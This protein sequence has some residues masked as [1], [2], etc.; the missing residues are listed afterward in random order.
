MKRNIQRTGLW[1]SFLCFITYTTTL[2]QEL[3]PAKEHRHISPGHTTYYIDPS[4]GK[5]ENAGTS[6]RKAWRTFTPVNQLQLT[7]GDKLEILPGAFQRSLVLMAQGDSAVHVTIHFAPGRYDFYPD[8]PY[9]QLLHISNTND[10]PDLPKAMAIYLD[11]SGYVDIQASGAIIVLRGKMIETCINQSHDVHIEG[12]SYDYFRPTVSEFT[13]TRVGDGFADL[14]IH[15]DSWY[16][17]QAGVLTWEGEGWRY[18]S[19]WYWQ[20]YDPE[21]DKVTRCD[22]GFQKA[23]FTS[24]GKQQ[25]RASFTLNPGFT[26]GCTYQTRDIRRDYTGIFMQRSKNLSLKNVRIFYMHGMGVV[27]Q[28]CENI[29]LDAVVVKPDEKSGRTCAAWA[30]ILHFS[31]CRGKIE[32]NHCYLSAANDDA[33][34]VHGTHL[35]ITGTPQPNQIRVRF[36]HDQSY[37]FTAFVPGDSISFIRSETLQSYADNVV[38]DTQRLSDREVL[39][40]LR[41]RIP[42]DIHSNDVVENSTWTPEVHVTHTIITHIP[43]R[44]ILVTTPR[45]V[46]LE[47]NTFLRTQS[48]GILV[49]D[50]AASWYE[51]G[52]IRD[53]TIRNNRFVHCGAPVIDIHPENKEEAAGKAVHQ[54]IVITNNKFERQD[55]LLLDAKSA[56]GIIFSNNKIA[57]AKGTTVE[58]LTRFTHCNDIH[59]AANQ[60]LPD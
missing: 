7:A 31:G 2:A 24:V 56:A 58:R 33:M 3:Y 11:H 10:A 14:Q 21:I 12:I 26:E 50:D 22:L 30:D 54:H 19:D 42:A 41:Q 52:R 51:S 8:Q 23:K 17:I 45:K 15:R 6:A 27:S 18:Q 46:V 16:T 1:F 32:V 13:V 20:R 40:T 34:N 43:T 29:A 44:G 39:L 38:A 53:L 49:A 37:G 59:I 60:L 36:M 4:K 5:D 35:R 25:V 55:G 57:G 47:H 48:G 28:Y 9:Q